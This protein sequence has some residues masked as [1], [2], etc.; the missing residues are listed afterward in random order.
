MARKQCP[1]CGRPT[2]ACYCEHVSTITTQSRV[3]ILQ[4]PRESRVAINTARIVRASLPGSDL[5][6][7]V[8]FGDEMRPWL[9]DPSRE[10]VLLYPGP[11]ARD[12]SQI[13]T[14]KPVTLV[15]I[16]G[17]WAQ[18]RSLLRRSP[19]LASLPRY[20]FVPVAESEYRIRREPRPD[21]VSTIESVAQVLAR[22]EGNPG[23]VEALMRP[24]RA[25]V[26]FQL[27]C[28]REDH[29]PRRLS[30]RRRRPRPKPTAILTER[31]RDLVCVAAQA[32][33]FPPGPASQD[34][35]EL[36]HF[37]ALRC[38]S[39]E[40]FE[41]IL[42]PSRPWTQEGLLLAEIGA[43]ELIEGQSREQ[44]P[45]AWDEFLR[46]TDVVCSWGYFPLTLL[47]WAGGKMPRAHVD[48]RALAKRWA[49]RGWT[50]LEGLAEE[51]GLESK[52]VG[53][54][55]VGRHVGLLEAAV[56]RMSEGRPVELTPSPGRG[57]RME[58]G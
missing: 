48:V 44:F 8:A 2:R 17:T 43:T 12:V 41:T 9:D 53:R 6:T 50:T 32:S 51:V 35:S 29:Q 26:D 30:E 14:Q 37:A 16:D 5:L 47:R 1:R 23:L 22:L 45:T 58:G 20:T 3:L 13:P 25:M 39:G 24:F 56:A 34:R 18:S 27:A 11:E 54:G 7:G 57:R 15:V 40:R 42:R 38:A 36:I 21:F 31:A 55:R 52:P 46:E 49:G 4:H 10:P 33:T 28:I 19:V